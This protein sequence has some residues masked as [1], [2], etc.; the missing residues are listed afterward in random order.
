[1]IKDLLEFY[2]RD[3]Q[4]ANHAIDHE[5]VVMLAELLEDLIKSVEDGCSRP[6]S[7]AALF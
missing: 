2:I 1:L 7:L 6:L 3:Q 4:D 5:S